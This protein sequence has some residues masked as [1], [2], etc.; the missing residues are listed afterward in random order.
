MWKLLPRDKYILD[1]VNELTA[2]TLKHFNPPEAK[3]ARRG[4]DY[5]GCVYEG[6][7]RMLDNLVEAK[8]AGDWKPT[9]KVCGYFK[10]MCICK[11][12]NGSKPFFLNDL[13]HNLI[14]P[15]VKIDVSP[16]FLRDSVALEA[17]MWTHASPNEFENTPKQEAKMEEKKQ[18]KITVMEWTHSVPTGISGYSTIYEQTVESLDLQ[19]VIKAVNILA[20]KPGAWEKVDKVD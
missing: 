6:F 14:T 4:N 20:G 19:A 12:W 10:D 16:T 3:M 18:Y 7:S 5:D 17:A 2:I 13:S 8:M 11:L 15:E 9:C 1:R